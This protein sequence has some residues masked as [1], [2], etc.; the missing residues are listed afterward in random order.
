MWVSFFLK[1]TN[2]NFEATLHKIL[3]SPYLIKVHP[4]RNMN[5]FNKFPY[6]S[7]CGSL[8]RCLTQQYISLAV[9]WWGPYCKFLLDS[10]LFLSAHTSGTEKLHQYKRSPR[11]RGRGAGKRSDCH[12]KP[13]AFSTEARTPQRHHNPANGLLLLLLNIAIKLRLI[14]REP[15]LHLSLDYRVII[16]A[17][18]KTERV[19]SGRPDHGHT[20]PGQLALTPSLSMIADA[21]QHSWLFQ[22]YSSSGG[23]HMQ[24]GEPQCAACSHN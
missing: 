22:L 13:V 20:R 23:H 4:P 10:L 7:S 12:R 5:V 14:A 9:K 24:Q 8:D 3:K 6:N 17:D 1:L 2:P 16:R 18:L 19:E 15:G 11:S 21:A